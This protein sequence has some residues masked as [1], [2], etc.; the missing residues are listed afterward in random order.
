MFTPSQVSLIA[1]HASDAGE[2]S[3][4]GHTVYASNV[5][6]RRYVV[7]GVAP[8]LVFPIGEARHTIRAAVRR[9]LAQGVEHA[10]TLGMWEDAG[11]VYVDAGD[12]WYL[13]EHA[14]EVARARGELAIY[15]REA[16][17]CIPVNAP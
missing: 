12:M 9:M 14:L 10:Q 4:T 6:R 16:G 8:A 3:G 5:M 17:E 1:R 7:G 11:S 13:L 2:G 15:D